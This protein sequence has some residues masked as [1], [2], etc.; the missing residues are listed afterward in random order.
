MSYDLPRNG[1]M[2]VMIL[3]ALVA[4]GLGCA[5]AKVTDIN[6]VGPKNLSRPSRVLVYDVAATMG[7]L[8]SGSSLAPF[9]SEREKQTAKD[10]EVGRALG[11]QIGEALTT[12]LRD[13]GL[14]AVRATGAGTSERLNDLVIRSAFAEVDKGSMALRVL[15]GFGAGANDLQT[16]FDVYSVTEQGRIPLG[17]AGIEAAGGYMPGMLLSMGIGGVVKGL[18]VGGTLAAG[19]EFTSES[20][21]G[22]AERTSKEFIETVKPDLVRRG[23]IKKD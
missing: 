19:K 13:L 17:T 9:A 11:A 10:V 23:W 3:S 1:L 22:A 4:L 21:E 2:R 8:A 6:R 16:H 12:R 18:A 15:I 5:S 20:L 7:D 14:P